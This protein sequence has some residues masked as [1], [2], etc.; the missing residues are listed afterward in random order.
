MRITNK[1]MQNNSLSNINSTKVAEDNLSSQISSGKKIVR[2]SDDPIIAIRALRLRSNVTEI[3]QYYKSNVPDAEAWLNTTEDAMQQVTEVITDMLKQYTKG[4]NEDLTSADR[5]IIL[6]QLKALRDE[7]YA[8]G[9]ADYAGRYVFTGYRTETS[10]MFPKDTKETYE[11]TEQFMA[12][13]LKIGTWIETCYPVE[14][15][16][17]DADGNPIQ[18]TEA[19]GTPK[20]DAEG[21]PV[22]ET[23]TVYKNFANLQEGTQANYTEVTEQNI[24]TTEYYRIRL[25][26]N[27]CDE[28]FTPT[29]SY[30]VEDADNSGQFV[31]NNILANKNAKST[32]VPSPYTSVGDDDV[33]YLSDTGEMLLGKNVYEALSALEDDPL[34]EEANEGEFRVTYRKTEFLDGDLRPQHYFYCKTAG[35]DG[36]VGDADLTDGVDTAADDIIYNPNYLTHNAPKQVIE[37]DVG[38]N[39]RL[40]VNTTA[41]EC[42][43]P[44]IAREVD[45]MVQILENVQQIENV[46]ETLKGMLEKETDD[47]KKAD[48][49]KQLDAA[50]KAYS[51][52]KENL[53]K[54]FESGIT[55]VQGFLDQ[56]N[57][58]V[59]NCGARGSR[60]ELVESRLSSQKTTFET[61]KSDNEDADL[62]EVAVQLTSAELTYEA[63]LKGT[64][65]IMQTNLMDF[66]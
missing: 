63:A 21:N 6:E 32:D 46:V 10:L 59:T 47:A 8:T 13:D 41:D 53:Q 58:A 65:K 1:I 57:V 40:Q 14:Q 38:F 37:Y 54:A 66:I 31:T 60:L 44:D 12:D 39:Q 23:E 61:L 62:A 9:D 20:F 52:A 34:T 15:N 30:L 2:P 64:A 48:L 42:F 27:N 5:N 28:G 50:N 22:Y 49:Q 16:K 7:V 35:K 25:A 56:T 26:Y 11:I 4:S 55:I 29:L 18:Q 3:T 45:D 51:Y 24:Q 43:D 33:V 19:D 17:L 36:V